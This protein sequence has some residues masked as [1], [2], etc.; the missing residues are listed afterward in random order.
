[1]QQI[2]KNVT[3]NPASSPKTTFKFQLLCKLLTPHSGANTAASALLLGTT[4]EACD[5][6]PHLRR[7]PPPSPQGPTQSPGS[8]VSSARAWRGSTAECPPAAP[9][10]PTR[11]ETATRRSAR[12][13]RTAR[14]RRTVRSEYH[15]LTTPS[16]SGAAGRRR[17]GTR[18]MGKW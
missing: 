6:L 5:R 9:R 17:M 11:T 15:H 18:K 8:S 1:M 16:R 4:S 7:V 14:W 10:V 12:C 2:S 3:K 13:G